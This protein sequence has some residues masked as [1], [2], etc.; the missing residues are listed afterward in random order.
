MWK[1]MAHSNN[2]A[3]YLAIRGENISQLARRLDISR[4]TAVNLYHNRTKLISFELVEKLLKHFNVTYEE[5]FPI[6]P[7]EPQT[8]NIIY[9]TQDASYL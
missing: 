6:L 9:E 2:I 5:L 7:D 3:K 1:E 4:D 8:G